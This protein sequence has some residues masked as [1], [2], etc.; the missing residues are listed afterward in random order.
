VLMIQQPATL[1]SPAAD[2]ETE[3][4]IRAPYTDR[5]NKN[6]PDLNT[7]LKTILLHTVKHYVQSYF[8]NHY[9]Q[10]LVTYRLVLK[11]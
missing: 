2:S 10:Q 5:R 1:H 7:H 11:I 6:L 8:S 3:P 9:L 4:A